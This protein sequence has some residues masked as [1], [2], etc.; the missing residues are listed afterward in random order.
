MVAF[1]QLDELVCSGTLAATHFSVRKLDFHPKGDLLAALCFDEL[2]R[3]YS[4][5]LFD[6]TNRKRVAPPINYAHSRNAIKW[7]PVADARILAVC[8]EI[9]K[10]QGEVQILSVHNL[11]K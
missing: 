10:D 11:N 3:K 8:G 5:E 9:D 1:W 2:Q 6:P 4:L 7:N